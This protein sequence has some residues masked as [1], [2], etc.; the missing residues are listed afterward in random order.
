MEE[1][2]SMLTSFLIKAME[3]HPTVS[4]LA[5]VLI[6]FEG[7]APIVESLAYKIVSY[8][9]TKDDDRLVK[10]VYPCQSPSPPAVVPGQTLSDEFFPVTRKLDGRNRAFRAFGDH[11]QHVP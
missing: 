2:A 9:K 4:S 11:V 10:Q 7:V 8:T 1:L 3:S 5:A 6:A